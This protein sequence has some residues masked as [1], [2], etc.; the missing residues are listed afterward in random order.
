M[1]RCVHFPVR[2]RKLHASGY[3][4]KDFTFVVM[5]NKRERCAVGRSS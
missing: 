5:A 1:A 4:H 2:D 3:S